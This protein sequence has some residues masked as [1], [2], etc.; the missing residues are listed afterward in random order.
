LF[1]LQESLQIRTPSPGQS[2]ATKIR[3][4]F[5]MRSLARIWSR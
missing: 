1:I 3:D 2:R 4:H 5:V